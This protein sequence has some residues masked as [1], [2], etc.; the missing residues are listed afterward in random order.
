MRS[1]KTTAALLAVLTLAALWGAS[2][3]YAAS[4]G[5]DQ[6]HAKHMQSGSTMMDSQTMPMTP[7]T[8]MEGTEMPMDSGDMD[9][10]HMTMD[11]VP[12]DAGQHMMPDGSTMDGQTHQ[13]MTPEGMDHSGMMHETA[14]GTTTKQ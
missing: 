1:L 6:T 8:H 4:H 9:M 5:E 13:N 3:T 12:G 10:E 11:G 14:P 2:G 7:G